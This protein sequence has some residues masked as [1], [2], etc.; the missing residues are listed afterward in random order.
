MSGLKFKRD[1][2]PKP[3]EPTVPAAEKSRYATFP[4]PL[5]AGGTIGVVSPASWSE[6]DTLARLTGLLESLGYQVVIH[7][8]NYL[9]YGRLAGTDAARAEAL[10]DMFTDPTI[11]A[12]LCARGGV[13]GSIR[14]AEALDYRLI[15]RNPKPFVGFSDITF[16]L[17]AITKRCG[18]VTYHGPVGLWLTRGHDPKT[19]DELFLMIGSAR[20]P[21]NLHISSVQCLRPGRAEG[22]LVGGNMTLLQ[23]LI[24]TPY[25]WSGKDAI[26]FL[27]DVDEVLYKLDR[28]LRHFRLAGKLK[29]VRA[30]LVGEMAGLTDGDSEKPFGR[31]LTQILTDIFP[32]GIPLGMNFPCGH[33]SYLTTLPVGAPVELSLGPHGIDL[34]FTQS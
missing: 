4:P 28:T 13:G 23:A 19:L 1:E 30:V 10:M 3:K 9:R 2:I 33:S 21:Y 25:D 17:Q 20:K 6:P 14:I 5:K 24:G 15:K 32:P 27:E 12:I 11:D 16:L 18:F 31:S 26:L 22:R 34:G 7:Q 29:D 8:Q